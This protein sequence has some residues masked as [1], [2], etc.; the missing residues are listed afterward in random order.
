MATPSSTNSDIS[1]TQMAIISSV[2]RTCASESLLE[3]YRSYKYIL[4][5]S[6]NIIIP[7][8]S[9]FF[10]VYAIK[11]LCAQSIIQYSTRVLL[12]T[13]ILFAV[14][15]QI[16]YFCFKADLLYT[17]LFKLDQPCNLQHSSYD[18]RFITIATTTSNCGMALVQLAMSIDRVFAL[19]FNRVYYKL[20]SIPGITLALITAVI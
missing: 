7:I 13:T 1:T 6:F 19:K 12:I 14:C 9:L 16:A 18:C 17:M 4:S 20:K 10:L 11:Q 2:N 15:H 3:L 5:T 8:I